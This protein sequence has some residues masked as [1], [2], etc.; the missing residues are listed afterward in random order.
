MKLNLIWIALLAACTAA[1][2]S[3][4]ARSKPMLNATST[5]ADHKNA[6]RQIYEVCLNTGNLDLAPRLFADDYLGPTGE[7][8]PAGFASTIQRMRA[9]M[10]DIHVEIQDLSAEGNRVWVRW[11]WAGTHRG[12]MR[13]FPATGRHVEISGMTMY[14]LRDGRVVRSL[15]ESDRLGFLQQIGAVPDDASLRASAAAR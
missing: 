7:V 5:T 1:D 15:V 4:S 11:K 3:P 6:I 8:G 2:A 14:E 13:G 12:T 9:G 10:P